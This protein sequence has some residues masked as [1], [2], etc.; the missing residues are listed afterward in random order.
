MKAWVDNYCHDHPL[1]YIA[2]AAATL[3][4]ALAKNPR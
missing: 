2:D 1:E 3:V 4:K